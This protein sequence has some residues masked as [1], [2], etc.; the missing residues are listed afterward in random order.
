MKILHVLQDKEKSSALFRNLVKGLEGEHLHQ[1]I[2]YLKGN[3]Q[4]KPFEI[5]ETEVF[6]MGRQTPRIFNPFLVF[7]ISQIIKDC[8]IDI[9]HCQRHKPTVYGTLAA[10]IAG[11]HIKVI[12]SVHGRNR[13]RGMARK[14]TNRFVFKRISKI[15]AVSKAVKTDI[16]RSNPGLKSGKV[17]TVYNGIEVEKFILSDL[18][19]KNAMK[20]VGISADNGT[21]FGTVGRLAPVKGQDV[22]LKAFAGVVQKHIHAWL[23]IAGTGPLKDELKKLA[24]ILSIQHRV[25]FLGYRKDIPE[26]L[27]AIDCFVL[28]SLSEGHPLSL[29]EAMAAE[30]MVIASDV[31]GVPEIL[32]APDIGVKVKPRSVEALANAMEKVCRMTTDERFTRGKMLRQQ[33]LKHYNTENM[34]K[35]TACLYREVNLKE[36]I[37]EQ[38]TETIHLQPEQTSDEAMENQADKGCLTEKQHWENRWDRVKLPAIIEPDTPNMV[39]GEILKVFDQYLPVSKPDVAFNVLEI[40]GAPG[41]F[42]AH[43]TKYR[44]YRAFAIDYSDVGCKKMK[45]NF[46][47]LGLDVTLYHRDFFDDLSDLPQFDLVFSMGFIEHFDDLNDVVGRHVKLVKKGGILVLGVPNFRGISQKVLSRLTPNLISMHNLEAMDI[48]RWDHFESIYGLEPMFKGYIGGFEP[49]NFRRCENKTLK[50]QA[51]RLFFKTARFLVTDPF[52]FL[53]RYNSVHWSAYLMGVYRVT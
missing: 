5:K 34:V 41:P 8:H 50:N 1:S 22:L 11:G 47:L 23:V 7:R 21:V 4:T 30:K 38:M 43:M 15:I 39:A 27:R 25:I 40:G 44:G 6:V 3:D 28:P 52:P 33:V 49:K 9:V 35:A 24:E 19:R 46:D 45:E 29:L 31:G 17:A 51:I 37:A 36:N 2:C 10:W 32:S 48:H 42:L 12:T 16:L 26:V 14:L 18:S 53:R 20:Q 13:T